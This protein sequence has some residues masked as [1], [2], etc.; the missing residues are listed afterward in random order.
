MQM[1]KKPIDDAATITYVKYI[2]IMRCTCDDVHIYCRLLYY[3][4]DCCCCV[5]YDAICCL[6][7]NTKYNNVQRPVAAYQ[8][9]IQY[10][11]LHIMKI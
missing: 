8:L 2:P 6:N 7:K 3:W 11:G 9:Q 4:V 1:A 5:K 10:N